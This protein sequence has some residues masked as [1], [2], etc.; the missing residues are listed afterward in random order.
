MSLFACCIGKKL[1]Q[2]LGNVAQVLCDLILVPNVIIISF[3]KL[4]RVVH[5]IISIMLTNNLIKIKF[6]II[7]LHIAMCSKLGITCVLYQTNHLKKFIRT[8]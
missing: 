2:K 5:S 8:S 4:F 3:I 1:P 6:V 7:L